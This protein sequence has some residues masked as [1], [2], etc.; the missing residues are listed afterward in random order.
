MLA[1]TLS[2]YQTRERTVSRLAPPAIS[3]LVPM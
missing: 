2:D 1:L 3:D